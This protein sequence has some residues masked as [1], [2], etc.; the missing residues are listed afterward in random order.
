MDFDCRRW[1]TF[2]GVELTMAE[3]ER[4]AARYAAAFAAFA[5]DSAVSHVAVR[6]L[7]AGDGLREG[8]LLSIDAG[9]TVVRRLLREEVIC[10]L[11]A[12]DGA[13]AVHIGFDLYMYVGSSE[14]CEQAMR[15]TETFGLFVETVTASPALVGRLK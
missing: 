7:E 3:Y 15:R 12:P 14:P 13:F 6:G 8:D 2:D 11:E 10:R 5:E 4:V 1:G 9:A